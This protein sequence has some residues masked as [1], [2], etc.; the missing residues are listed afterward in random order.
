MTQQA[1]LSE[2]TLD[3][4]LAGKYL[5]FRLGSEEYGLEILKVREIIQMQTLTT[6]PRTP[7]H[8]RGVLNLHGRVIPAI[9]LHLRFG[10]DAS[11]SDRASVIVIVQVDDIEVGLIVDS[12]SE[13]LD[14]PGSDI[15]ETPALGRQV[16]TSFILGLAKRDGRVTMLLNVDKVLTATDVATAETINDQG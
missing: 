2:S 10:L 12:V 4:P 16:D 6:V 11:E 15:E 3:N 8:V 14:V 7:E 9:D 13:A 1:T 5:I